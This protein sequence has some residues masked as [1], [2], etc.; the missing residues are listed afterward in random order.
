MAQDFVRVAFFLGHSRGSEA[1]RL[2]KECGLLDEALTYHA[3][4]DAWG[5]GVH[6]GVHLRLRRDDPRVSELMER[7]R[8]LDPDASSYPEREYSAREID[9]ASWLWMTVATA[10]L[11]GGVDFNQGYD[12]ARACSTCGAGAVVIPPLIADLG[13]MGRKDV[14]HVIHEGHL[15]ARRLVADVLA[16]AGLSGFEAAPVRSPRGQP[17]KDFVWL[18]IGHELPPMCTDFEGAEVDPP[19]PACARSGYGVNG[20]GVFELR[21]DGLPRDLPDFNLTREYWGDP[22]Q[23]RRSAEHPPVGGARMVVVSQ[24]VRQALLAA[25]VRRLAWHP[26]GIASRETG[27]ERRV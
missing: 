9:E 8:V 1:K 6:T 24:R 23:Q 25:K 27:F 4:R 11:W 10:G 2:L 18:R 26:V 13:K 12:H 16:K 14:E 15:I 5:H 22:R 19:C 20:R 3:N 21:Y 17:S 7:L